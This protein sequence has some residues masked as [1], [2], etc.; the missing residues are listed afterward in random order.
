MS[1]SSS[2]R[3]ARLPLASRV[4]GIVRAPRATFAAVVAHP[5]WLGVLILTVT[6]ATVTA[7][8]LYS[9][10]I[11]R[12]ALLDQRVDLLEGFGQTV[13]DERYA[14][15]EQD[16]PGLS[17]L[18]LG[19]TALGLP[20]L[21]FGIAGVSQ[22]VYRNSSPAP[23]TFAQALAVVAHAGVVLIVRALVLA[24]WNYVRESLGSPLNLSVLF[25]SLEEGSF[26]SSFLGSFDL[27][28]VWWG[29]VLAVGL[30]V[31]YHRSTRSVAI[32]IFATYGVMAIAIAGAK[33]ALGGQ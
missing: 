24:P 7:M 19:M 14:R 32:T 9:T 22:L 6:V 21:V 3:P 28:V 29:L 1:L 25:P 27:F 2:D 8:A 4:W 17:R 31:L 18:Q 26:L 23:T 20:L 13:D 10:E 11:G 33:S 16:I 12:Q 15:L 30:G 5:T